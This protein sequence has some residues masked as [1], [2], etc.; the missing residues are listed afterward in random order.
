MKFLSWL[1]LTLALCLNVDAADYT[2]NFFPAKKGKKFARFID[3]S[4]GVR[5]TDLGSTLQTVK[6]PGPNLLSVGGWELCSPDAQDYLGEQ[7]YI[8]FTCRFPADVDHIESVEIY[9][10][11][12]NNYLPASIRLLSRSGYTFKTN[13]TAAETWGTIPAIKSPT[14]VKA[15]IH[16]EGGFY[17]DSERPVSFRI[18]A[19]GT[20]E[21]YKGRNEKTKSIHIDKI[22]F[23]TSAAP[24]TEASAVNQIDS[25]EN[26]Q[27]VVLDF[28]W[29]AAQLGLTVKVDEER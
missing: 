1:I 20:K 21:G 16:R 27:P 7:G 25:L 9:A 10:S 18:Y 24:E 28:D 5:T 6:S 17:I 3:D 12:G 15:V 4:A 14:P 2:L 22:I 11:A 13:P 8:G 29:Q 26:S 19:D 23:R